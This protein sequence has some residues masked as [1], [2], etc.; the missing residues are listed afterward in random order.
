MKILLIQPPL[1][2][3]IIGAG[4][5]YLTEP[6]ALEI[7]ASSVPE[8]NV[9]IID[10][11]IDNNL[12][13]ELKNINPD[14]VGITGCTTDVDKNKEI[15]KKVKEFN[16]NILT[17][18]GGH[19]ATM[20]PEDFNENYVDIVV[21]GE[22]EVT[23]RELVEMYEKKDKLSNVAGIAFRNGSKDLFYT[24]P[25]E[26]TK[27]MDDMPFPNRKLTSQYRNKYFRGSWRPV[28]SIMSSKG[29]PFRCS[30]CALWKINNGKYFVRSPESVVNELESIDEKFI[31]FAED[32]ALHDIS[33]SNKIY[34]LIKQRGIKK[35]Y[36]LY[37]R[38]D[39]IVRHP[40]IIEKWRSIG[41]ELVLVGLE[42]FRDDELR[43][44]N[45][46][47]TIKNNEE[48]I[49]ILHKNGVEVVAY[50]IV[51][52]NYTKDDF[53]KLSEY[54]QRLKLKQ[55]I[56]TVLTPLPGTDFYKQ[57]YNELTSHN[58]QLFDFV[59]SVLPTKLPLQEFYSNLLNLYNKFYLTENN[60]DGKLF[61]SNKMLQQV[62]DL[63]S[64][65]HNF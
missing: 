46:S 10:M 43:D 59:H 17:V 21:I 7:I 51:N 62:H 1:N 8:H 56:F 52:P 48:A 61:T 11:R 16:K 38:S 2:P 26:V 40:D 12:E 50:F 36:K 55:P 54:V 15:L 34:E 42:S 5:A 9:N 41:M 65:A 33:R 57:K 64:K 35:T 53:K 28:A 23:F 22:G 45:K 30:F 20:I 3:N 14:I 44:L 6:L 60:K 63:L 29:C 58:Y 32:N 13:Q 25:R 49:S 31:D 24:K 18:V 39:T 19:H 4:I 27:N 37:A 47:N